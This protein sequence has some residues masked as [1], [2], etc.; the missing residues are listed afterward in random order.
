[1]G[2]SNFSIIAE[3][4]AG[5]AILFEGLEYLISSFIYAAYCD[6]FDKLLSSF[7]VVIRDDQIAEEHFLKHVEDSVGIFRIGEANRFAGYGVDMSFSSEC[8][9]KLGEVFKVG[10]GISVEGRRIF[11][12]ELVE[13]KEAFDGIFV[14]L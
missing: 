13:F 7:E 14:L 9:Y 6:F 3:T 11:I 2:S 4:V 8:T 1:L 10:K 5:K 12:V